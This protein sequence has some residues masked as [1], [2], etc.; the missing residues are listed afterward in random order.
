M[1]QGMWGPLEANCGAVGEGHDAVDKRCGAVDAG[2][3][4]V[5]DNE[6][7]SWDRRPRKFSC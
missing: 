6:G 4:K 3:E 7:V 5:V 2:I 1:E